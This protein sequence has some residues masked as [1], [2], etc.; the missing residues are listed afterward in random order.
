MRE[1][2]QVAVLLMLIQMPAD[3]AFLIL[4]QSRDKGFSKRLSF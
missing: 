1:L 3:L 4:L 2:I